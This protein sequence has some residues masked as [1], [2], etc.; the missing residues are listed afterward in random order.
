MYGVYSVAYKVLLQT[1][2][3]LQHTNW[4][5]CQ[6]MGHFDKG[7]KMVK[8]FH[9]IKRKYWMLKWLDQG[10]KATYDEDS[11]SQTVII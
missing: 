5:S 7:F 11:K 10:Y 1:I 8:I 3:W 4:D 2:F 9:R 6:V